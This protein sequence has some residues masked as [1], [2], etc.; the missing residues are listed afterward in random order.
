M[1]IVFVV[2]N[3]NNRI[4]KVLSGIV[5]YCRQWS[6]GSAEFIYTERKLHAVEL[7]TQAAQNGCDFIVAVGGDGTLHEVV[8]GVLQSKIS[9]GK[10][11]VIGLLP[12]G[13]AN[14]FARTANISSAVE[15]LLELIKNNSVQ[16]IDL[17]KIHMQ[18]SNEYRY[19]INIAGIGL[20]PEVVQS[21]E[22]S[23]GVLGPKLS[24][25][26]HIIQGFL[27]YRK[28]DVKV[29][30]NTWEWNGK[31]LQMAVANGRYY[32]HAICTA[33]DASLTDGQFQ[34]VVF[35]DLSV[36]DYLKN[37]GILKKGILIKHK[38]VHYFESDVVHIKSNQP[39]GIEADGE[40][41]G[42]APVTIAII[43]K[44]I[45]FLMPVDKS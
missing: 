42:L 5:D 4:A 23:S 11:P 3:K 45:R 22:R 13:S 37:L 44:A 19:F 26:K 1:K 31:L 17:G 25:F 30:G 43:P 34:V 16:E 35:G 15:E 9:K 28:K 29:I 14:D 12:L 36:W 6:L 21:L 33:P 40:Y 18:Q 39:C 32:G 41:L 24:Y 10:Y 27:S 8:N 7:A 38:E 2:N 20:G